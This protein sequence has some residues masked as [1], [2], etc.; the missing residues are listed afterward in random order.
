MK[1]EIRRRQKQ[2]FSEDEKK[3]LLRLASDEAMMTARTMLMEEL[4]QAGGNGTS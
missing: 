1:A 2:G 3:E 4:H